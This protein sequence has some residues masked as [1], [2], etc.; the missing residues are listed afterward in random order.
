[1]FHR[2]IPGFINQIQYQIQYMI[3]P[4]KFYPNKPVDTHV[5]ENSSQY[6]DCTGLD[7]YDVLAQ[8]YNSSLP[9]GLGVLQAKYE[10]MDRENAKLILDS[11]FNT[12]Y[13]Y[14]RPIKT[15]FNNWPLLYPGTY[16]KY[17]GDPGMMHRLIAKL[18]TT[19]K[20]SMEIPVEQPEYEINGMI[21]EFDQGIKIIKNEEH[22]KI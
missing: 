5:Q 6:V 9:K 4:H 18:R 8:L 3:N 11:N 15:S 2:F 1:M 7:P 16:D 19:G 14:G 22:D 21:K 13:V 20:V 17:N 12:D 10:A